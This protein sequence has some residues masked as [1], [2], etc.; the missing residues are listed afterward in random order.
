MANRDLVQHEL[1]RDTVEEFNGP[2]VDLIAT[3]Q[4]FVDETPSESRDTLVIEG[5]CNWEGPDD[6]RI[7]YSRPETDEE[8]ADS[9]ASRKVYEDG[10]TRREKETLKKLKEKYE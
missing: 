5:E 3:L 8:I 10:V 9:A 7:Y 2:V 6:I 1:F 4:G